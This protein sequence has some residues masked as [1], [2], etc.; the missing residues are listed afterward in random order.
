SAIRFITEGVAGPLGRPLALASF[1]PQ[2]YAW[3]DLPSAFL[4][5][6]ICIHLLNGVLVVWFIY[7]LT[8]ARDATSQAG[9]FAVMTG[10]VWMVL[11]ILVSSSLLIVQRMTT[12]SATFTLFGLIGYLYCRRLLEEKPRL[13]LALM[14]LALAL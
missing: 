2:A 1:V 12:L 14:T 8:R 6:N 7:C 4:Y 10:F 5:I 9:W 13:S 11:P 3:P